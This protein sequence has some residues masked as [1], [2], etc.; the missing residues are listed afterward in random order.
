MNELLFLPGTTGHRGEGH[1]DTGGSHLPWLGAEVIGGSEFNG[2]NW[3]FNSAK[4]GDFTGSWENFGSLAVKI[5][6]E[7]GR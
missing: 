1:G 5:N 3:D 4:V 6:D 2:E 7:L